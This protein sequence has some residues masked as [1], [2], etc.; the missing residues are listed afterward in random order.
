MMLIQEVVN[1]SDY[2]IMNSNTQDKVSFVF[3]NGDNPPSNTR[4]FILKS[5]CDTI[6]EA[7]QCKSLVA[8][9]KT[10]APIKRKA[11]LALQYQVMSYIEYEEHTSESKQW[12]L[13]YAIKYKNV[14]VAKTLFEPGIAKHVI[15]ISLALRAIETNDKD[16]R[17]YKSLVTSLFPNIQKVSLSGTHLTYRNEKMPY[18]RRNYQRMIQQAA[19][20]E[21]AKQ[22]VMNNKTC[23][24]PDCMYCARKYGQVDLFLHFYHAAKNNNHAMPSTTVD[25]VYL[26]M[27]PHVDQLK[28]MLNAYSPHEI[29]IQ[30]ALDYAIKLNHEEC[31]CLLV[32]ALNR[33]KDGDHVCKTRSHCIDTCLAYNKTNIANALI[34]DSR[35]CSCILKQE[36]FMNFDC[37][38][39]IDMLWHQYPQRSLFSMACSTGNM[40]ALRRITSECIQNKCKEHNTSVKDVLNVES[41]FCFDWLDDEFYDKCLT[42]ARRHGHWSVLRWILYNPA[43]ATLVTDYNHVISKQYKDAVLNNDKRYEHMLKPFIS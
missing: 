37:R 31:A 5:K 19:H 34:Q 13:Y 42:E 7:V 23:V 24:N 11:K 27:K 18:N 20:G 39:F 10:R 6:Q 38:E 15:I 28:Q 16:Y 4:R 3:C 8:F 33:L 14:A 30:I 40:Y 29:C 25:M 35:Q 21:A 32:Q 17:E 1:A 9:L 12:L 43:L 22:Q 36:A 2:L 41:V 26:V